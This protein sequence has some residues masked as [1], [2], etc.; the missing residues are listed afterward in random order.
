MFANFGRF[1]PAPYIRG[2]DPP[3][4]S[5]GVDTFRAINAVAF[6]IPILII[7]GIE[8]E[9]TALMTITE[10]A[11]DYLV[12]GTY[13]A[14]LLVS[15]ILYATERKQ[16]EVVTHEYMN[17]I[18]NANEAIITLTHNGVIKG[19]N[20]AA[21]TLLQYSLK[22]IAGLYFGVLVPE[23]QKIMVEQMLHLTQLGGS[24]TQ[25]EI[26]FKDKN[27]KIINCI[28]NMSPIKN[29]NGICE[30][31]VVMAQDNT[32]RKKTEILLA[33]QL[34]VSTILGEF[35]NLQL[36]FHGILKA[37]CEILD[38]K[39]GEFWAVD[40]EKKHM[41]YASSWIDYHLPGDLL[42]TSHKLTFHPAEGIPGFVWTTKRPYWNTD[43]ENVGPSSL[44]NIL[45][46]IKLSCVLAIPILFGEDVL[47]VFIFYGRQLEKPDI[48]MMLLY[49]Q[50]GKQIGTFLKRKRME[51]DLIQLAEHDYLTGLANKFM[52]EKVLKEVIHSA[53]E[54]KDKVALLYLDLDYFKKINDLVGHSYGDKV[55]QEIAARLRSLT[56]E[57][58]LIARF[59]G[60]EFGIILPGIKTRNRVNGLAKKILDIV[61]LPFVLD[62]KN[63]YLTASIGISL[64][65]D[66]GD[67]VNTLLI[68]ADSALYHVKSEGRNGYQYASKISG[69]I[70]REK[71][72][73]ESLLPNA[74]ENNEFLLYY[75][76]ILSA[77]TNLIEGVEALIRWRSQDGRILTPNEFMLL[78]EQ[79]PLMIPVGEWILRT[80]CHQIKQW[81]NLGLKNVAVNVSIK[82]LNSDFVPLIKKILNETGVKPENL[83][84]E[85]TESMLVKEREHVALILKDLN[86]IG[87]S[88]SIDD[89][90]TGY[91]S[92]SYLEIFNFSI[93]KIDKSFV[94]K[95]HKSKT[96]NS[97]IEALVAM[98]KI[99]KLH[100]IAEGVEQKDQ[101]EFLSKIGCDQYQGYYFSKPLP[102]NEITKLLSARPY[103]K[104]SAP[105]DP[106]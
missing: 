54:K 73:I 85:I 60:D 50:I 103:V 89:F 59:G 56:R 51:K 49:E 65:P 26:N 12:K 79:S 69:L 15:S 27:Q 19:L 64:Y 68:A 22:E 42:K 25:H 3:L 20:N 13:D 76:P 66:D 87:V 1:K 43:L 11:Q 24:I 74:F 16:N 40:S 98:S 72:M 90:G 92:F 101:L 34:Q 63:F 5:A 61:S 99:L 95:I 106:L 86:N 102:A 46:K 31:L 29:K 93:L 37:I 100:T 67:N 83:V 41:V 97:I 55:L 84:I 17:I 71:L 48:P 2:F 7:T 53:E 32:E 82:Q 45:K 105:R 21:Q 10:G 9:N 39:I 81:D 23:A 38:F 62:G 28:I 14:H 52:A 30:G 80:A 78:L 58:D 77:K 96:A 47:G 35:T 6:N 4:T 104:S 75:Q 44:K 57:N 33:I 94:D 8:D 88:C 18:E 91:S 70:E 36:V